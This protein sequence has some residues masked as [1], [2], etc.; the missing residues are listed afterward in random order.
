MIGRNQIN[1]T[2]IG[3]FKVSDWITKFPPESQ[4]FCW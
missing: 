1:N 3:D 4:S 2:F